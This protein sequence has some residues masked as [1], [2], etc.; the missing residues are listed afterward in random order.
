[1]VHNTTLIAFAGLPAHLPNRSATHK[2]AQDRIARCRPRAAPL[3]RRAFWA[4]PRASPTMCDPAPP[5]A[6]E[7]GVYLQRR[8]LERDTRHGR[9][10]R[11]QI[12]TTSK[13]LELDDYADSVEVSVMAQPIRAHFRVRGAVSSSVTLECDRCLSSF[14]RDTRGS[15]EVYLSASGVERVQ[16]LTDEEFVALEAV[17]DFSGPDATV[18]LAPHARDALLLAQPTKALCREDCPGIKLADVSAG[19]VTYAG[20]TPPG[21]A[22]PAEK[23]GNMFGEDASRRLLGLKEMLDK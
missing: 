21:G 11:I 20:A 4:R 10:S 19:S 22:T 2:N 17:E 3:R 14:S 23:G 15:F 9:V 6:P 16:G 18:D 7:S 12:Q 8:D 5:A 1:M 13:V